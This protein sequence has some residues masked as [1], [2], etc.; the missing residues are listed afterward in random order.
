MENKLTNK[1]KYIKTLFIPNQK[2]SKKES[3]SEEKVLNIIKKISAIGNRAGYVGLNI[4][5]NKEKAE[6][7]KHKYDVWIAKEVKKDLNLLEKSNDLCLILDWAISTTC[8]LFQYNFNAAKLKQDLWHKDLIKN[9]NI[10]EIKQQK[11]DL[12]RILYRCS[13][14]DFF[15]YMLSE[16]DLTYEGR[17]MKNCIGQKHYKN[18]LKN[19][20]S[21][22]ISLRDKDNEPHIT[23]EIDIESKTIIQQFGKTNKKPQQKYIEKILEF[24]LFYTNYNW[25]NDKNKIKAL[26]LNNL[27]Y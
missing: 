13:D 23:T 22:Y 2:N 10:Q 15:I 14:E 19:N 8:D 3:L 5:Q 24:V 21:L 9:L 27:M 16:D 17:Q 11:V 1:E 20:K 4:S 6:K 18:K 7:R 26:N 25:I 12:S